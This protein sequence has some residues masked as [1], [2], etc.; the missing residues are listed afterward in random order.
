VFWVLEPLRNHGDLR[1]LMMDLAMSADPFACRGTFGTA[2][3]QRPTRHGVRPGRR[4]DPLGNTLRCRRPQL[5]P[6]E[7]IRVEGLRIDGPRLAHPLRPDTRQSD[8]DLTL[9]IERWE[10]LPDAI[11]AGIVAMVRAASPRSSNR[12]PDDDHRRAAIE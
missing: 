1:L 2:G 5:D 12:R 9:V 6:P 8:P 4:A 7:A 11:R 10:A 3:T